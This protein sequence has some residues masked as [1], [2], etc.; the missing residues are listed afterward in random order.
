[1]AERLIANTSKAGDI[2]VFPVGLDHLRESYDQN[3]LKVHLKAKGW[4]MLA[5]K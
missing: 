5:N 2:S 1:M 4:K 3:T